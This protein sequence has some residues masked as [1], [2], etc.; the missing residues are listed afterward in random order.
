MG[1][2]RDDIDQALKQI[3]LELTG[4]LHDIGTQLGQMGVT[5]LYDTELT[6]E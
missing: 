6:G 4:D 1:D 5:T 2:V 3:G